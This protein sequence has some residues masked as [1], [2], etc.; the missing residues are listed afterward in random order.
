MNEID[1]ISTI[2]RENLDERNYFN[3]LIESAYEEQM[4]SEDDIV[5][6]QIQILQLL[7]EIVYK[8]NGLDKALQDLE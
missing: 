7:D 1:I 4:L 2:K 8:Y 3:S 6:I 5:N